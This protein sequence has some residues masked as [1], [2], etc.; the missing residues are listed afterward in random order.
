MPELPIVLRLLAIFGPVFTRPSF[1]LFV[2]LVEGWILCPTRRTIT[3]IYP[4]ADPNRSKGV[5]E[6]HYFFRS[7]VW[8]QDAVFR[9]WTRYLVK[10]LFANKKTLVLS[11]DDTVHK[12]TGRKIDGARVCRDAVR[13]TQKD[14]VLC[15]ALQFIPLCLVFNPPWG[16]E[17]LSLPLNV[18]LNRKAK[19]GEAPVTILDHAEAMLRQLAEWLP[20]HD[21]ILVADGAYASLARR[22]IPRL[23]L[24]SRMRRDAK[25]YGIPPM[26]CPGKSG[27][28]RI[29]GELLPKPAALA[30]QIPVSK[31]RLVQTCERG[32][33]RE[34][35]IYAIP[36][37]WAHVSKR[38]VLLIISRDWSGKEADDFFF[39]TSLAL[40]PVLAVTFFADRWSIEDTFRNVKQYLGSEQPQ[41]WKGVGPERSGAFSYL[42]YGIVW[43]ARLEREGKKVAAIEREWYSEKEDASFLD[44]LA[45]IRQRLWAV[46][47]FAISNRNSNFKNIQKLLVQAL[48]WAG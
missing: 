18:R 48:A 22:D 29:K 38:P 30:A 8:A 24:V 21:F 5:Q 40:D 37:V 16:K 32:V 26:R 28:P 14:T 9:V 12:K 1:V 13:S 33:V 11:V 47:I 44:A 4:F 10:R 45:D 27:R 34:R 23:V 31:W 39:S 17:P 41:S 42:I 20:E 6:Y 36:V 7:A 2:T 19:D 35:L 25:I 46:R 15:W 3:G 43:M